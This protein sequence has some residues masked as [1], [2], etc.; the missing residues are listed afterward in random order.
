[1]TNYALTNMAKEVFA[2][3]HIVGATVIPCGPLAD[4]E[5]I[6][7]PYTTAKNGWKAGDKIEADWYETNTLFSTIKGQAEAYTISNWKTL[8]TSLSI[9]ESQGVEGTTH[10]GSGTY[11]ETGYLLRYCYENSVQVSSVNDNLI[12]GIVFVGQILDDKGVAVPVLYKYKGK[13]FRTLKQL[14]MDDLGKKLTISENSDAAAIKEVGIET[15][16]D[17]KCYYYAG[18]KHLDNG[19][20]DYTYNDANEK[21]YDTEEGVGNME[22]A[23]MRN[24]IYSLAI[25]GISGIGSSTLELTAGS[26]VADQSAFIDVECRIIDWIVRFNDIQF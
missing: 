9:S 5:S 18:I 26:N 25:S 12:S 11:S 22:F 23:I 10:T 3:L 16:K 20:S 21:I 6:L 13:F 2:V 4:D 24:N 19:A 8:P 1:M 17:G 15:Y 7:D 14:L